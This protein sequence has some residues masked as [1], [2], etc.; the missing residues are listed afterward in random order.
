MPHTIHTCLHTH[1]QVLIH[2]SAA[3]I[4]NLGKFSAQASMKSTYAVRKEKQANIW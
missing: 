2:K 3:V 4:H 1:D